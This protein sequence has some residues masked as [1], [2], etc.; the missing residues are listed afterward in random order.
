MT[1]GS[2]M[3]RYLALLLIPLV[4]ASAGCA[5]KKK[6]KDY[7]K[8]L[9]PGELALREVDIKQVPDLAKLADTRFLK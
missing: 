2:S 1:L 6:A 8:Q 9:N 5:R 7:T 3:T 4:L